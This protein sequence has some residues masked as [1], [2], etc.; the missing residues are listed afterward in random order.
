MG[1]SIGWFG[2]PGVNR[3]GTKTHLVTKGGPVCGARISAKAEYQWCGPVSN[4][5]PECRHCQRIMHRD[6]PKPVTFVTVRKGMWLT[7][8]W[9]QKCK[10]EKVDRRGKQVLTRRKDNAGWWNTP[11]RWTEVEFDLRQFSRR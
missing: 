7:D 6:A 8:K 5:I 3:A 2:I 10:V 1:P 4:L 9:N 11:A